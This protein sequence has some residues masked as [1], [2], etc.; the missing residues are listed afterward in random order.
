[1][2]QKISAQS[3]G[4]RIQKL[5]VGILIGFLVIGFAIWG[6]NDVFSPS[7]NN[8]V[9]TIGDSEI[10]GM[11][12][13]RAFKRELEAMALES[14]SQLSHSEAYRQGVHARVL[15]GLIQQSVISVD[16]D[17]LG[18]GVNR[19][20]AREEVS[21]I[22]VFK[23]ELT[24]EFSEKKYESILAQN[25]ITRAEFESDVERDLR[26]AQTVPAI[27]DGVEA[28]AEFAEQR[29]KFLTE[30]RKAR[31][32][33]INRDAVADPE[34][35]DDETLKAFI[36][37]REAA[38]TAPEYRQF[39]MLRIEDFDLTPN[40]EI[41]KDEL[42]AA[43]EYR[44]ELG[45]LGSAETRSVVQI[46][47]PD[48]AGAQKAADLLQTDQEPSVIASG[49]GHEILSYS[50]A[51]PDDITDPETSKAAF[52]MNDGDIKVLLGS[53][54]QWY[55]VKVT[56]ITPAVVPDF[57]TMK[58]ELTESLRGEFAQEKLYDLTSQIEGLMDE[59][60][61]FED[62]AKETGVTLQSFDYIDRLGQ[63]RDGVKMS[64]IAH[65]LGVA[66]DDIILQEIFTNDLGY[67][68]DLFETSNGGWAAV[69][70]TSVVDS[71]LRPF[72]EVKDQAIAMWKTLQ[73]DEAINE[74]MLETA[75]KAQ[76]GTPLDDLAKE[77]GSGASIEE[78]I[79]VRSAQSDVVGPTV[80]VGLLEGKVGDIKRGQGLKPLTRQ[81]AELTAI[82]ANTD[83]LA[84]QFSDVLQEQASV[85]IRAD[86]QR[87]YQNAVIAENPLVEKPE[88]IKSLLGIDSDS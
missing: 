77:I 43:F 74:L 60:V 79:L 71:V 24:G 78:T 55:A 19:F 4:S 62:I 29:Y 22:D 85:A 23:D 15:G 59:S 88:K 46:I 2:S 80:A 83:G 51:S 70:V 61:S 84:G 56:A 67:E 50:D 6:I 34:T 41:K 81:I 12:F 72:D 10:D 64:G 9:A 1:M 7:S 68:T 28:P 42:K 20:V 52:A 75:S 11:E 49:L 54:G 13:E 69:K 76:T 21:N 26:R 40:I 86:L 3:I 17:D 45:E 35:P 16:A 36:A 82:V 5:F 30:Q 65:L 18:I 32:L 57:D 38:F 8:A 44:V 25:R 27:I 73:V 31:V 63:T 66:E 58:E 37:E 53:L 48:Q 39:M 47:S 87:A 14:G 33:T